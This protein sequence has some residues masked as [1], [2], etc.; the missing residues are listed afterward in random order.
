MKAKK[1]FTTEVTEFLT[2]KFNLEYVKPAASATSA[3]IFEFF[4]V[5][6]FL[7][8]DLCGLF[9]EKEVSNG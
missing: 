5:R 1:T 2:I 9:F 3:V 4:L 8:C 6:Q 7:L